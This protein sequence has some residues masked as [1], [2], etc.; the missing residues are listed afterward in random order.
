MRC[1]VSFFLNWT[2]SVI[3]SLLSSWNSTG[4]ISSD[5]SVEILTSSLFLSSCLSE[6]I[7]KEIWNYWMLAKWQQLRTDENKE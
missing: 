5:W 7:R 6:L 1:Q 4:I 3:S 2:F